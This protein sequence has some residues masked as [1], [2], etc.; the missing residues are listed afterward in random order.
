M[1]R[2]ASSM[3]VKRSVA[4]VGAPPL[5]LKNTAGF[6]ALWLPSVSSRTPCWGVGSR[7]KVKSSPAVP[8]VTV[9]G[10][11]TDSPATSRRPSVTVTVLCS[12]A[13]PAP[14]TT[15]PL[16]SPPDAETVTDTGA[17]SATWNTGDMA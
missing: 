11:V 7:A 1:V 14:S 10:T 6:W 5:P 4:D 8:P 16:A 2:L 13:S 15:L 12:V 3:W 9:S 17:V